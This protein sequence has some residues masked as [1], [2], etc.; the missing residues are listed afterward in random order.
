MS[1]TNVKLY[2]ELVARALYARHLYYHPETE[3]EHPDMISDADYDALERRIK[4]FEKRQ[5]WA[6]YGS[7][8]FTVGG[9]RYGPGCEE[10]ENMF[11]DYD[12]NWHK[13]EL[14]K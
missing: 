6:T 4:S 3:Y 2:Y 14:R 10:W 7:P 11:P 5:G 9:E 8:T 12:P 13:K 1:L